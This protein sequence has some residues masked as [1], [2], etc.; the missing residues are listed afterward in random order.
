MINALVWVLTAPKDKLPHSSVEPLV[1][2]ILP[3]RFVLPDCPTVTF[4]VTVNL[5]LPLDAK[6]RDAV[7]LAPLLICMEAQA[8]L[9][10]FTVRVTPSLIITASA[11]VGTGFPP[12]VAVLFQLP[13]VLAVLWAKVFATKSKLMIIISIAVFLKS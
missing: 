4:P 6:A 1:K 5:G 9:V 3:S 7:F 11:D 2:V 10:T 8:A 12:Q 13:L